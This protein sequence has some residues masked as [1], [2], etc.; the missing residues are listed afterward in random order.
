MV[1]ILF[2]N[3]TANLALNEEVNG[4][5]LL[6]TKLLQA[7]HRVKILRF[8][9]FESNEVDYPSFIT[10]ITNKILEIAPKCLSFYS[11][12]PQYHIMLRIA[13]EVKKRNSNIVVVFGGPQASATARNTMNAMPFVDY[14][15]TGEGENTVVPFFEA[16]FAG[17]KGDLSS[18]PGL[19]Y[20]RGDEVI[21]N[22]VLVPLCDLDALPRWD[23]RLYMDDYREAGAEVNADV[24]Y[25]PIDAGRGCPFSCTFCCTSHFWRRT[26]RLKSARTIVNDILYYRNKYGIKS[27]WFSHDAFTVNMALV[28]QVCDYM[29]EA[30][31]TDIV[32]RCTSR[33]DCITEELVTKMKQAGLNEIELGVE[34][35]SPRMQKL[36]NKNLRLEQVEK[37]VAFLLKNKIRVSLF[38]MYGFPE[39]TE[40]DLNKTLEM[41]FSLLDFGVHNVT[42][43]FCRFNPQT[44]ITEKYFDDLVLDSEIQVLLRTGTFG[45]NEE[46]DMIRNNKA[47]FPFYYHLDTPVRNKFQYVSMFVGL[48]KRLRRTMKMLRD[49]YKGDNLA[50]YRDYISSNS[51]VFEKEFADMDQYRIDHATELVEN[52]ICAIDVSGKEKLKAFLQFEADCNHILRE[53]EDASV[54]RVYDFS[55]IDFKLGL[56][57]EQ[58]TDGKTEI[59]IQKKNGAVDMKVLRIE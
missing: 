13:S 30:G 38:F 10:E 54:R 37:A 3:P 58:F 16:V 25:M 57:I 17:G 8:A 36:I 26:Y 49:H 4:T 53:K 28:E 34:T 20:R 18:V 24:K 21:F 55:Y 23:E 5:M 39:E 44:A 32:W 40:E 43:A 47:L 15:C 19:Y 45:Y 11:L 29:I 50:F 56:P 9:Q 41:I 33:I 14:I 6:A 7:G 52:M 59:L 35:G 51:Y 48:Y 1:D 2:I 22:D 12:W 27:F 42:M 31:L 46:V